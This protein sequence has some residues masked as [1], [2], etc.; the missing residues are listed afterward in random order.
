MFMS[1]ITRRAMLKRTLVGAGGAVVANFGAL[2]GSQTVADEVRRSG[3]RCILLWANGGASQIDTFDMKPGQPTG[4]PFRPIQTN[5]PGLQIC[6][7]LPRLARL[8]DKLAIIR[9][10]QTS[11]P[12]H[13][14]G[15]YLMHTGYRPTV[16]LSHPELGAMVAKYCGNPDSDLPNFIRMGSTGNAGSGFLGPQYQPFSLDR[17]GRLG[18]FTSSGLPAEQERRRA[19]LLRFVEEGFARDNRAEPYEAHRRAQESVWRLQARRS[20]FDISQEWSRAKERYGD[21]SYGRSCFMA[22]RLIEAGVAFVECGQENYDS[23][24]DNF[25]CHK[26]NLNILDPAWSA[27]LT[28]L[29]DRGLLANTLVIWMGEVGRTPQINNRAGRD[30][31]VRGWSIVLAGGGVRGGVV[32]G[33]TERNG[34]GVRENPVTESDFFAT[35]YTALGINPR[36]RHMVGTRPIWATPEGSRV[37]R[38]IL[39]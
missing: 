28:D 6:E 10:M 29:H 13:P 31:F 14:G 1:H 23:H 25:V 30:H 38:E 11:E 20:V 27:L 19:E 9:S 36:V 15:I 24:N 37:I 4:G 35:V 2:F 17:E 32:Y 22:L 26:A 16:N 21:T 34:N 8:A 18:Y 7:Y 33:A 39:A 5:V 3:K 12:D